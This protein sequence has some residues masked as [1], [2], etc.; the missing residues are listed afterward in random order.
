MEQLIRKLKKF[1]IELERDKSQIFVLE[2]GQDITEFIKHCH[3]PED[4]LSLAN[5]IRDELIDVDGGDFQDLN[6]FRG[7]FAEANA[8]NYVDRYGNE[9][10][11]VDL[12]PDEDE[13]EDHSTAKSVIE[14]YHSGIL[15]EENMPASDSEEEEDFLKTGVEVI[16]N[17]LRFDAYWKTWGQ[18]FGS[19]GYKYPQ[20]L[21]DLCFDSPY[22]IIDI[23]EFHD[24][25]SNGSLTAVGVNTIDPGAQETNLDEQKLIY[26]RRFYAGEL[27]EM[28]I[29][30]LANSVI[31][32]C[33][34][35]QGDED[36]YVEMEGEYEAEIEEDLEN[37]YDMVKSE[38]NFT[39]WGSSHDTTS[40]PPPYM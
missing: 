1:T 32:Y 33:K 29:I 15:N 12:N 24:E 28:E 19:L 40:P 27:T 18:C 37:Y 25:V 35:E 22:D 34:D 6:G 30:I 13:G 23:L 38:C 20:M 5:K 26:I 21:D 17:N 8:S 31:E 11:Q 14:K 39:C 2:N 4:I 16:L 36:L 7:N 10:E 3:S 9:Q